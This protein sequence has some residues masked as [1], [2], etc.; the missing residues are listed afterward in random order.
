MY[1]QTDTRKI[2]QKHLFFPSYHQYFEFDSINGHIFTAQNYSGLALYLD[3]NKYK[4]QHC[5]KFIRSMYTYIFPLFPKTA[6][7]AMGSS[8]S[9][10]AYRNKLYD[11]CCT[12]IPSIV[13]F[14][15]L[16]SDIAGKSLFVGIYR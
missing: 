15:S 13:I 10:L 11:T 9:C 16:Q 5:T 2:R 12:N 1:T 3:Q 8:L 4:N 14:P 7:S 6:Q